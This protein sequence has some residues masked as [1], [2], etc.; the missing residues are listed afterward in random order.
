ML[1]SQS[2]GLAREVI[3]WHNKELQNSKI[4]VFGKLPTLVQR[5][6]NKF[7]LFVNTSAIF[8]NTNKQ[9]ESAK[10]LTS[11]ISFASGSVFE[12]ERRNCSEYWPVLNSVSYL[13]SPVFTR[14]CPFGQ[15]QLQLLYPIRRGPQGSQI[16]P[17]VTTGF[18]WICLLYIVFHTITRRHVGYLYSIVPP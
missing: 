2:I 4:D 17:S 18:S 13:I 8:V 5:F 10:K 16:P 9:T 6:E 15:I 12:M 3:F 7:F 14:G 1:V 11:L